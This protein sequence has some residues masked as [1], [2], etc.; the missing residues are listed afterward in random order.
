MAMRKPHP[1]LFSIIAIDDVDESS[2]DELYVG[3]KQISDCPGI[4]F[5][6]MI[7][8]DVENFD[9]IIFSHLSNGADE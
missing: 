6:V 2:W 8:S 1:I 5:V 9:V 3:A 4:H 7:S